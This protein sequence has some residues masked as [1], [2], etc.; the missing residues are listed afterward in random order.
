MGFDSSGMLK[1]FCVS[2]SKSASGS[3][4]RRVTVSYGP[5]TSCERICTGSA[6]ASSGAAFPPAPE[7]EEPAYESPFEPHCGALSA[8]IAE[9]LPPAQQPPVPSLVERPVWPLDVRP[10]LPP[11]PP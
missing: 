2:H 5:T 9:S 1:P 11:P 3:S 4:E 7:E 10:L 8:N 6:A